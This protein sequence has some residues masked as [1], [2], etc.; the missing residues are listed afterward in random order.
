L[1]SRIAAEPL[2]S[3]VRTVAR[4]A[5][6]HTA[7]FLAIWLASI[8]VFAAAF[9]KNVE[10]LWFVVDAALVALGGGVVYVGRAYL[11]FSVLGARKGLKLILIV[12]VGMGSVLVCWG[13]I[14]DWNMVALDESNYLLTLREERIIPD[15]LLPFNIRWLVPFFAG[16][17]NILPVADMDAIKAINFGAFVVTAVGLILLLIRL[18]VRPGLAI[19]APAFLLSSYF[20]IY[21]ASNRL[22]LDPANYA[23]YV[24][25][26]HA[27]L[28]R[29]HWPYFAMILLVDALNAEKAVYWIPVFVFVRLLHDGPPWTRRSL[30]EVA[31]VSLYTL[32]PTLIYLAVL[33]IYLAPSRLEANLCF[34]NIHHMSFSNIGGAITE[35]VRSNNFQTLWMPFGPFTIFALLG[36][37]LDSSRWMKPIV[38]L[39]LP[40]FVQAVIA[41]DTD[42]M[43]AYAF[44][45]YLPFGYLYLQRASLELPRALFTSLFAALLLLT[46][47]EH[48]L[49][50]VAQQLQWRLPLHPNV[51]KMVLSATEIAVVIGLLFAHFTFYATRRERDHR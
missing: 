3:S 19:A 25:L 21:G 8:L 17:W 6:V 11:G 15:G 26:F 24:L 5:I 22:V 37:A 18:R 36:F 29:E 32:A 28:R 13:A 30:L 7:L 20:G 45:V 31:K 35:N 41:C 42:R 2:P 27:L 4:V 1:L 44:V 40:I 43:L 48:Y 10:P 49:F 33:W 46:V 47:C 50:P 39:V 9:A 38:L 16:R 23:L 51:M 12:V 14:R 34:E